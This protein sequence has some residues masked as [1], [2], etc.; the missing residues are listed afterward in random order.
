MILPPRHIGEKREPTKPNTLRIGNNDFR[1][2]P[3]DMSSAESSTLEIL[4]SCCVDYNF[5]WDGGIIVGASTVF[6]SF[7]SIKAA[8]ELGRPFWDSQMLLSAFRSLEMHIANDTASSVSC[9]VA[10]IPKITMI[11]LLT[12]HSD[13]ILLERFGMLATC[14]R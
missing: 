6:G 5:K 9:T 2:N 4:G 14:S 3:L 12:L 13:Y 7:L 8:I 10:S 1:H 11:N